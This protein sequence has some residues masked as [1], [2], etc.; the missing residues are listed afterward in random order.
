MTNGYNSG[1]ASLCSVIRSR[2]RLSYCNDGDFV[3]TGNFVVGAAHLSYVGSVSTKAIREMK[4]LA[5][6]R[7]KSTN[8]LQ[9]R[10]C[11]LKLG[12]FD[13][14]VYLSSL[15]Q[16]VLGWLQFSKQLILE[17][18]VEPFLA[19]KDMGITL[20]GNKDFMRETEMFKVDN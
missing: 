3:C 15:Q 11:N 14:P 4:K 19:G 18:W 1:R 2:A 17:S 20:S 9:N 5:N 12:V 8:Y 10:D 6:S 7:T 16:C 13:A